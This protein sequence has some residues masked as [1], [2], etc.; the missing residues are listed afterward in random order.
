MKTHITAEKR[1]S[2]VWLWE[3]M[4]RRMNP[5]IEDWFNHIPMA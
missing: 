2:S 1:M 4:P 5:S 3:K